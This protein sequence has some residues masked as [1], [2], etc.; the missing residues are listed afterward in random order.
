VEVAELLNLVRVRSVAVG[1]RD[2][3]D[4]RQPLELRMGEADAPPVVDL[5][6]AAV[7]VPVAVRAERRSGVVH[8]QRPQPVESDALFE[9][10]HASVERRAI[11]DVDARDPEVARVE[12]DAETRVAV[13]P[14]HEDGQL[15]HRATDRPTGAR[16]VLDQEPGRVRAALERAFESG[17]DVLEPGFE[18]GAEV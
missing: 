8:V 4:R 13:Q 12:A 3:E 17:D 10:V 2:L 14:L 16:R 11:R 1:A 18:A 7:C 15:V 9:L 6:L 5:P